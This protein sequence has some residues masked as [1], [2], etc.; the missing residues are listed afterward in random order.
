M[1]PSYL[2]TIKQLFKQR[3][4][5]KAALKAP[6]CQAKTIHHID[7]IR[8]KAR[9]IKAIAIDFDGVLAYHGAKIISEASHEWLLR[10]FKTFGDNGVYIHSN[11]NQPNRLNCLQADFPS[12]QILQP[13]K[14]KPSTEGLASIMKK[15]HLSAAAI[16]MVDDR[17]ATGIL[18]AVLIGAKPIFIR[19]ATISLLRA[20]LAE[21]FFMLLRLLER[22]III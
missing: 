11:N 15:D 20:P 3:Q 19:R 9:G 8:L 10:C 21:I 16:A 14:K 1:S 4:Q 12:I 18:A 17:I 5:I 2:Q 6:L 7:L 22:L 13:A